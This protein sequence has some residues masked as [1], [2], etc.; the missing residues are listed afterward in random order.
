M[1]E[2]LG[3]EEGYGACI[4]STSLAGTR[5]ELP[6]TQERAQALPPLHGTSPFGEMAQERC[7]SPTL[8]LSLTGGGCRLEE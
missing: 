4:S 8:L 7:L 1:R 3:E 2:G 5:P 6:V